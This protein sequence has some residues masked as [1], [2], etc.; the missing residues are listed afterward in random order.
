MGIVIEVTTVD[1]S[2][3]E[4]DAL[5]AFTAVMQGKSA[6]LASTARPGANVHGLGPDG[7]APKVEPVAEVAEEPSGGNI[8]GDASAVEIAANGLPPAVLVVPEG[9]ELDSTGIPWDGRIHASTKTKT[10]PGAWTTKRNVDA[11]LVVQVEAELRKALAAP[12]APPPPTEGTAPAAPPP[13]TTGI[14]VEG[15][16]AA[17]PAPPPP[18]TSPQVGEGTPAAPPPPPEGGVAGDTPFTVFMRMIVAKQTAGT[19]STALTN[20][21]AASLG[22]TSIRDLATRPDLI[23]T[24]EALLP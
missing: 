16:A 5:A 19:I 13:P 7:A 1:M 6:L 18:T 17:P 24:F 21:I 12:A 11:D 2:P 22:L 23:P 20:E 14:Q 4:W 3:R 9:A 8:A 10:K 15:S